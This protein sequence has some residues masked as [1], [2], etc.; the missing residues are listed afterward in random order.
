MRRLADKLSEM[1]LDRPVKTVLVLLILGVVAASVAARLEFDTAFDALL[2][3]DTPELLEVR[4]LQKKAGGTVNLMIAVGGRK[5]G[6]LPFARKVVAAL[7]QKPF[8]RNAEVE[9]P[10][11]FFTDRRIYFLSLTELRDLESKVS[12]EISKARA[13]ANPLYVDLEDDGQARHKDLAW[14]RFRRLEQDS[15][16]NMLLR[17]TLESDDGKY[18]FIRAKPTGTSYNMSAGKVLLENIK[19][20]V[21]AQGPQSY[22]VFVQYAGA[23]AMNQD[24]HQKMTSDLRRS[25]LIAL[26]L[27]LALLTL[28]TR[29]LIATVVFAVPLLTGL[30]VTLAVVQILFGQLNLVSG[31]LVSALIGLGIDYEIHLYLRYLEELERGLPPR[32]AME[33]A[34]RRTLGGN[35]TAGMT[36][37]AAFLAIAV[38]HFRGFREYGLIAGIGVLLTLTITCLMLPPLAVLVSKRGKRGLPVFSRSTFRRRF[39]WSMV[40]VGSLALAYSIMVAPQVRWNSNFKKLRGTNEVTKF[41]FYV[42]EAL[43]GSLSPAAIYVE[44]LDQA[45]RT[46]DFLEPLTK[47][48]E[49]TLQRTVS[50]AQLV[51]LGLAEKAKL[52][53]RMHAKLADL[54]KEDLKPADRKN[55]DKALRLTRAKPWTL[56]QV[57]EVFRRPFRTVDGKGQFVIIWPRSEMV[58]EPDIV[59]WGEELTRIRTD[60]RARGIPASILGENRIGARVLREMRSEAPVILTA[61]GIAV[62]LILI[63]DTRSPKKVVLISGA[64]AVG[65]AWMLGVMYVVNLEINVFNMAVLATIIGL[66]L[67][68]AVHIQHRYAEEGRGS[69]PK[70]V[71]TTGGASFLASATTAIGFGAAV[72]AH[73]NGVQTLGWLA[74]IGFTCTFVSSTVFFP[75]VLRVL[76]GSQQQGVDED[77]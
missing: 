12:V 54:A 48:P 30:A 70:V 14:Q 43:G 72:T 39:A 29:K 9:L 24:Q 35:I 61:A 71:A 40:V 55:V 47:S 56:E 10:T 28:Y 19:A 34:L 68:N 25:S 1:V 59:R 77:R 45:R 67:D 42:E 21:N 4:A 66:G 5:A 69:L 53:Q 46:Q 17:R 60:L 11:D 3:Q 37:A 38:A 74:L 51:P 52:V 63:M 22:G 65:L 41:T 49:S 32:R 26:A 27:I 75:A 2:E 31:F 7:Q 64:L 73:H 44:D 16:R 6:R 76:E 13:R 23:L 15:E 62:L 33:E 8:I 20:T 58:D 57:P 18:L 50:Q 36:T